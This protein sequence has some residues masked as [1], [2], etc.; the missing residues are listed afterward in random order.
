MNPTHFLFSNEDGNRHNNDRKLFLF[1]L[2]LIVALA[3]ICLL[4]L[5]TLG[6]LH[7]VSPSPPTSP[8]DTSD[9]STGSLG[10]DLPVL[11]NPEDV[12]LTQTEDAGIEYIGKMVFFGESTTSHLSSRP[13]LPIDASQ[14]WKDSSGT[15]MLSAQITSQK[16]NVGEAKL[17]IAEACAQEKPEF[18]VLSFGLNG[19][20][21]FINDKSSYTKNYSKL[22]NTIQQ[23]S[24]ETKIILQTVYPVS[25]TGNFNYDLET[26]NRHIMTLNEW[27]PEI[28]AAHENVR[29]VDTA[30]VLR[31]IEGTLGSAYDVGDGQHLTADAYLAILDYLRTHAWQ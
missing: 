7:F 20:P 27:I 1:F 21:G 22:I 4:S 29:V 8:I 10:A 15:K 3:V 19:L 2:V 18:V 11:Q 26:L 14:V 30:S 12:I 6:I 25:Q 16:I 13:G 23:A 17:T 28:A 31:N 9:Q 5:I 24:P